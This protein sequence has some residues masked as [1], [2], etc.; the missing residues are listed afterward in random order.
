[1]VLAKDASEKDIY[2]SKKRL[3]D[4]QKQRKLD[5]EMK[6][7]IDIVNSHSKKLRSIIRRKVNNELR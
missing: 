3:R 7:A 5:L 1:M 2:E 6:Q 4:R